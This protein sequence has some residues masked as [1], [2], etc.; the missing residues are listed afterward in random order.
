MKKIRV[1]SAVALGIG[2]LVVAMP[3][4][5]AATITVTVG[6]SIQTAIDNAN[7]GDTIKIGSGTFHE[8]VVVYKDNLTIIG[9]NTIIQPPT[10]SSF[11]V[12]IEADPACSGTST[13]INDVT[14]SGITV[15][16]TANGDGFEA[17][18]ANGLTLTNDRALN[19]KGDGFFVLGTNGA[20]LT[21]DV[22]TG[23]KY[24]GFELGEDSGVVLT[25]DQA[26]NNKSGFFFGVFDDVTLRSSISKSN[27]YGLAMFYAFDS[28]EVSNN[29]F[30]GNTKA[31]PDDGTLPATKGVGAF[32][33][34]SEGVLFTHNA[35]QGN[36]KA[37]A[38][39]STGGLV[40][41]YTPL[42]AGNVFSENSFANNLP[43]DIRTDS[44]YPV[45]N[46]F[47]H[48]ACS[49]SVPSGLCP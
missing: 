43:V 33:E 31:C 23:N 28:V 2:T 3:S 29:V 24:Q 14:I 13:Q 21:Q 17:I 42:D 30:T 35:L 18:E 32:L 46:I 20:T 4:A 48:N 11:G 27:C 45:D 6:Q 38:N 44:T 25:S 36:G 26:T 39:Q 22:A 16:N 10:L 40:I 37:T 12:C 15:Q 7:P 47:T 19:N 5:H 1:L 41:T 34:F 49:I 9:H 8:A